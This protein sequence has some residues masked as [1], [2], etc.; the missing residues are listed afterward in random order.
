MPGVASITLC[1]FW[2]NSSSFLFPCCCI[3]SMWNSSLSSLSYCN[4][5]LFFLGLFNNFY[6]KII[7]YTMFS[8]LNPLESYMSSFNYFFTSSIEVFPSPFIVPYISSLPIDINQLSIL[9][10]WD[11][12]VSVVGSSILSSCNTKSSKLPNNSSFASSTITTS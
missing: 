9:I 4:S 3:F 6:K 2:W 8:M 5:L 12:K 7:S 1:I 11:P 10:I